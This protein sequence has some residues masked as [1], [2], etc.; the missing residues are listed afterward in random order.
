MPA[1]DA[2][3]IFTG[4][5]VSYD[6]VATILSL[7]QDPRWRRAMVDAIDARPTDRVLDVAT[8][9]GMVAQA[10]H[11]RYACVVTGV[12]QSAD[13]LRVARTRSGV[14]E[15]VV[16]A[17][18]ER[19]PFAEA[20]FDHLTFT[21]LLRYVDDPAATMRELARVVKPGGRLAMVEFGVPAGI[22]RPP[23]WL[24]TR[25]GLPLL[26]RVVSATW[27]AVGSFLGPSID[28]F[29]ADHPL[30]AIERYWRAAGLDNVRT[31][32]MSL[33]GGVV[34]TAT[35]AAARG[36]EPPG[37][38]AVVA[39]ASAAAE[40]PGAASLAPEALAPAFY[41]ARGGGWRDY[42][43]LLH[44]PY[45]AWHLSYVLLGA[46][47]SP[48]PDPRIVAGALVAFGLAV[49]V[50]AHAF[51]ELRGRP[52]RTRIPSPV[53]VSLGTAALVVAVAL[54]LLATTMLG[55]LFLLFVIGGPA[56]VLAY[57]F[58]VP[59]VHSDVGFALGWGAFPV[60]TTAFATGAH[61]VPTALAALAATLLS[62]AQRR[63]STR[64]RS[65][66]RRAVGIRGEIVYADGS[67]EPIDARSLIGAPE[68]ALSVLWLALCAIALAVLLAHWL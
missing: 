57:G 33:G 51:D 47:L 1:A 56:I 59:I 32:R 37:G 14:F 48:T 26:G 27:S 61:P 67:H 5:A 45:T 60:V 52:L 62:L 23:W 55:P 9:T 21:Y 66:R 2:D 25:V 22:W 43:T 13:M 6:R 15:E 29:Y 46:A 58:E 10:L 30:A 19:L 8:G 39:P 16:E 49:G 38:S 64:A 34:M 24:Y 4:I 7:G 65:I 44:P 50:G 12:D 11:D 42:W 40:A 20:A 17:R 53:L 3:R 36:V 18:A 28:R 63:L 68:G 41:A 54:G 35:K 31:R